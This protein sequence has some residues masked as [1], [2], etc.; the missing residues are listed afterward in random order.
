MH[1]P[2][3]I[4]LFYLKKSFSINIYILKSYNF[5]YFLFSNPWSYFKIRLLILNFYYLVFLIQ[6]HMTYF[7]NSTWSW[8]YKNILYFIYVIWYYYQFYVY[9]Y[10]SQIFAIIINNNLFIKPFFFSRCSMILFL[11]LCISNQE[12]F[13][14]SFDDS[15]V[16]CWYFYLKVSMLKNYSGIQE[17]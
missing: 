16:I 8:N 10:T 15:S 12:Y 7:Y 5:F 2:A 14:P 17:E 6:F 11:N 3:I 4:L 1:K 13:P 9:F